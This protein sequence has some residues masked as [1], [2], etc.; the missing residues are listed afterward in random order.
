MKKQWMITGLILWP[1][2][3]V[4]AEA[5][6]ASSEGGLYAVG[7]AIAIAVA[8]IGGAIGQGLI[9]ASAMEGIARNPQAQKSM[10]V[11]FILGLAFIE[12]IVIFSLLIAIMILGKF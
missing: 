5:V 6:A 2:F 11:S 4:S 1:T 10:F 7:A 3:S 8:A 9:G 12:T